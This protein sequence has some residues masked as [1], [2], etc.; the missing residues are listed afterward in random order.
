MNKDSE[1]VHEICR[2]CA[3]RYTCHDAVDKSLSE[4]EELGCEYKGVMEKPVG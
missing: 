1:I 2:D 3:Y 4:L